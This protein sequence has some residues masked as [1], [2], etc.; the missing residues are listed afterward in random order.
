MS[1]DIMQMLNFWAIIA[2]IFEPEKIMRCIFEEIEK[3]LGSRNTVYFI[4]YEL[5]KR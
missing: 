5:L 3:F 2:N 1:T 4:C